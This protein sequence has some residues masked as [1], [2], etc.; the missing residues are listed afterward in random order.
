M[1]TYINRGRDS[2]STDMPSYDDALTLELH[3]TRFWLLCLFLERAVS[4][5]LNLLVPQGFA[6]STL[7][8]VESCLAVKH[9]SFHQHHCQSL[10]SVDTLVFRHALDRSSQFFNL[11]T[12]MKWMIGSLAL[13]I[14]MQNVQALP[15]GPI[16]SGPPDVPNPLPTATI[17]ITTTFNSSITSVQ[18][19]T[20]NALP[21]TT[22][23][24]NI[25]SSGCW[26]LT[27]CKPTS[28]SATQ[29]P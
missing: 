13:T 5:I 22:G 29:A 18:S 11:K 21:D 2:T 8:K 23:V 9:L 27:C 3:S 10:P 25:F 12:I 28:L 7:F 26:H 17:P 24:S 20:T 15:Q 16:N 1:S 14:C 19:T 4:S 6:S